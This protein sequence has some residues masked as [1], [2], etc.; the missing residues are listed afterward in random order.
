ME[1]TW[2]GVDGFPGYFVSS[3]GRVRG[4]SGRILRPCIVRGGYHQYNFCRG[5]E[6]VPKRGHRMVAEAFIPGVAG[7]M[8]VN[9]LNNIKGD[10]RVE[11]LEWCTAK[12]NSRHAAELGVQGRKDRKATFEQC[13]VAT[14]HV[15]SG[16]LQADGA[17]LAGLEASYVSRLVNGHC[18]RN[19]LREALTL[20]ACPLGRCPTRRQWPRARLFVGTALAP[21]R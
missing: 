19:V 10:N 17:R 6:R 18:R 11:N 14:V 5:K 16:G 3:T 9:H 12:E 1:E 15:L 4:M 13:L 21:A 20:R 7:K 2:K 8:F